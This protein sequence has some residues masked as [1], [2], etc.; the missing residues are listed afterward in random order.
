M[1]VLFLP[2][3]SA[4]FHKFTALNILDNGTKEKKKEKVVVDE[5]KLAGIETLKNWTASQNLRPLEQYELVEF[6]FY[7][8]STYVSVYYL[9]L[10]SKV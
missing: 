6:I 9:L 2:C 4:H 5:I 10:L 7:V 1:L 3:R 8:Y